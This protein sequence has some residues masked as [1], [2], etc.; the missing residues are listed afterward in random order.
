MKRRRAALALSAALLIGSAAPRLMAQEAPPGKRFSILQLNDVYKVEGL[1]HM[2]VGGL[3]RVRTL[4]R[5]LEA[6]GTPVLVLHAGDLLGPSVMSKYLRAAPMIRCL[7][8]LDGDAAAFDPRLVVIPGNH[9]L[10]DKDPGLLLGRMA[11]SDFEWVTSNVLYRTSKGAKGRPLSERLRHVHETLVVDLG[12]VKVGILGVTTDVQARD[13]V[14]YG[15]DHATIDKT[16]RSSLDALARDGARVTIAV[17]HEDMAEDVRVAKAFPEIALV[18]GGHE[19]FFQTRQI[20][21]AW[22]TKGDSD[23][24][25]V[26]VIDVTVPPEGAIEAKP[27]RV[28]LGPDVAPDPLVEAE[29]KASLAELAKAIKAET[30]R[31]MD[32]AVATT[33]NLLEGVEPAVRSRETALGDLL[34]D[35][36][37]GRMETD[38]AFLNGGA[39]RNNDDIPAGSPITAYDM[40]GIFYFDNELVAFELTGAEILELLRKSVSEAHAGHGRFLQV[41]GIRFKYHVGGTPEAP[42]AKVGPEDVAIGGEPLDLAKKY[43]CGSSDYVWKNGSHDGYGIFSL[44]RGKTSPKLLERPKTSWRRATEEWLAALPGHRVTTKIDGRITRVPE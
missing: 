24:R 25:S 30:G 43:S 40:E 16:I 39:I 29:A 10:D 15:Y 27:R 8:L 42:T 33:E 21:N 7:N 3:A 41:S 20:G 17:T 13:Y 4:R 19:H 32:E 34:A 12:G 9:E 5:Q 35:V 26:V 18:V 22:I 11:Q 14:D 23:A 36:V 1:E 31:D 28:F 37:K 2:R 38:V 6:E 44:G